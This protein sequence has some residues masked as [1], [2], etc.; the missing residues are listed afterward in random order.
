[1]TADSA[2]GDLSPETSGPFLARPPA[3]GTGPAEPG[4]WLTASAWLPATLLGALEEG[5]SADGDHALDVAFRQAGPLD[6]MPP[7]PVLA[8]FLSECSAPATESSP[9]PI[10]STADATEDSGASAERTNLAG[11][12][13]S[14]AGPRSTGGSGTADADSGEPEADERAGKCGAEVPESLAARIASGSGWLSVRTTP[15]WA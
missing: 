3:I 1:V 9:P 6:E 10:D 4:M 14:P 7:G 11:P 5:A 13:S 15:C 2:P 12:D 8:A